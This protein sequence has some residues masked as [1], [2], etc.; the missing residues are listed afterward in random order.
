[1]D[2]AEVGLL[3]AVLVLPVLL[4]A[5]TGVAGRPWWWAAAVC[6]A[7]V[8]VAA[9]AP[10]PEPGESRLVAGDL[11]FLLVVAAFVSGLVWVSAWVARRTRGRGRP[12]A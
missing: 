10:E 12:V 4:G 7:A 1:M 3:L 11:V 9:V 8:L 2:G 6:V 5:W